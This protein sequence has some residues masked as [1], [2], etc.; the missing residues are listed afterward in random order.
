M[1]CKL[2]F[3]LGL[4]LSMLETSSQIVNFGEAVTKCEFGRSC[5]KKLNLE[6]GAVEQS[7]RKMRLDK[8]VTNEL[9]TAN[10]GS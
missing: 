4:V 6:W 10:L 9:V 2:A 3:A 8:K 7:L 1:H 5:L